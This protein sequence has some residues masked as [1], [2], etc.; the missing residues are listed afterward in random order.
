MARS[1]STPPE[2]RPEAVE[3]NEPSG[4]TVKLTYSGPPG[5]VVAGLGV[6]L[7]TGESY[8]VPEEIAESLKNGSAF[9]E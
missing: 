2:Q 3:A 4:K 7:E 8:E 6:V 1:R 9:W 5:Q